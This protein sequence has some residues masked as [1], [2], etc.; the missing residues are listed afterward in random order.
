VIERRLVVASLN[1]AK[2]REIA[3]ILAAEG[4][5]VEVLS[6]ADFADATL[7]PETGSTFAENALAKAR[8]VARLTGL[9]AVADDS[10]L[11]VDALGG[12]PG[13]RS[14]RYVEACPES[15]RRGGDEARYRKVLDLMRAVPDRQRIGRFR[16]A[17]AYATPAGE[18]AVAEGVCEGAIARVPAGSRGFG[19][20]P[21]FIPAGDTRTMAQLSPPQKHAISHRGKAFRALARM[22]LSQH[23]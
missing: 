14:A 16:C 18:A 13:I 3:Q 5:A 8:H 19:Y 11:E 2:A 21:I 20:D 15:S 23:S 1:R 12:E 22:I 7:P 6:L 10:G 4:L 9:P 17:A